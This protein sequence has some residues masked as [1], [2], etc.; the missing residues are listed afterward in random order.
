MSESADLPPDDYPPPEGGA[1]ADPYE[2]SA[3]L[4]IPGAGTIAMAMLISSLSI[5]FIASMV[6][7]GIIRAHTENWG[8]NFPHVPRSLW[9]ST[10]VILVAS[11]TVQKAFTA[12][13]RD[14][15]VKLV[16]NLQLTFIIGVAFLIL[17]SINWAEFYHA[18]R[19]IQLSGAYLGMF[20]VLT[21]LHAAHVVGGL[22]PL[23]VVIARAKKDRYSRNFHPGVRYV[24]IYWHFLDV[25]WVVLFSLIYF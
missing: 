25:V 5:L 6:A 2:H 21:G 10:A 23:G 18:I 14:D 3:P 16:R 19:D 8:H 12:V 1:A 22:I 20:F 7:Y 9:I 13:R 4:H 17:Q 15:N 24:T 11:V